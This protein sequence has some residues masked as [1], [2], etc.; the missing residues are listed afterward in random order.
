MERTITFI[1]GGTITRH[2]LAGLRRVK[3][4]PYSRI[5]IVDPDRTARERQAVLDNQSVTDKPDCSVVE[6]DIVVLATKPQSFGS[7][8]DS[9]VPLGYNIQTYNTDICVVSLMAGVSIPTIK[10]SLPWATNVVR[11]MPNLCS[12]SGVGTTVC[13]VT[14]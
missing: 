7:V 6:S 12:A 1:G 10:R 13:T 14:D 2:I 8:V 11:A 5:C 9:L 3:P 4:Q